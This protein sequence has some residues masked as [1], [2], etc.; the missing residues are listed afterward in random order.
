MQADI[1]KRSDNRTTSTRKIIRY[2]NELLALIE[3][4]RGDET[5]SSWVQSACKEKLSKANLLIEKS[6]K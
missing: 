6:E 1:K 3:D 5:F 2:N 4:V